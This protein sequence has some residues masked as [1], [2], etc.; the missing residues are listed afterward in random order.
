MMIIAT[1]TLA[2]FTFLLNRLLLKHAPKGSKFPLC[3]SDRELM[4]KVPAGRSNMPREIKWYLENWNL[5]E[6]VIQRFICRK[7]GRELWIA[8]QVG[9]MEKSLFVGRVA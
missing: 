1:F 4:I 6:I 7:C 3:L 5:S 2:L 8:P 9:D